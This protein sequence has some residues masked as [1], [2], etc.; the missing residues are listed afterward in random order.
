MNP[1]KCWMCGGPAD[2][3]EHKI[4]KTDLKSTLRK[5]TQKSP[6]FYRDHKKS[7]VPIGSFDNR[8][9]KSDAPFCS[10][11]NTTKTQS[12]DK[13]W[14]ALSDGLRNHNPKL[15]NGLLVR[16]NRIFANDV[17]KKMLAVHLYFIKLFGCLIAENDINIDL[18]GFSSAA[19]GGTHHP[20]VYLEVGFFDQ[21]GTGGSDLK[22]CVGGDG[23]CAFACWVYEI[24]GLAV[25]V[26][27]A[28]GNEFQDQID[29]CWHPR[30]QSTRIRISKF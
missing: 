5:P 19:M 7:N 20:D 24:K 13:A 4:K 3:H 30:L 23:T 25:K 17:E 27:F 28:P 29:R 2:S 15:S 26:V 18:K 22:T 21:P 1:Q 14:V 16:L 8:W 6:L 9:L 12:Y 10:D 11:C